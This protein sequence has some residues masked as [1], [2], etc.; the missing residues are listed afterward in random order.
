MFCF[1]LKPGLTS[2]T[3]C[4]ASGQTA[5]EIAD[6][7]GSAIDDGRGSVNNPCALSAALAASA[8]TTAAAFT[9]SL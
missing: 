7:C 6:D 9:A 4:A 5:D 3:L 8:F 1:P 2:A